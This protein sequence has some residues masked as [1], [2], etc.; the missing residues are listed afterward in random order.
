MRV[1]LA[2][3]TVPPNTEWIIDGGPPSVG[4]SV[5]VDVT[6]GQSRTI[7]ARTPDDNV[8]SLTAYFRYDT[9]PKNNPLSYS[10]VSGNIRDDQALIADENSNWRTTA[11]P[12]DTAYAEILTRINP[13]DVTI[14]GT[15]SYDGDDGKAQYNWLL[16]QR[17]AEGLRALLNDRYDPDFTGADEP[18][19]ASFSISWRDNVWRTQ[20]EPNRSR[21]WKA[22]ITGFLVNFP[23]EVITGMCGDRT[24]PIRHLP[25]KSLTHLPVNRQRRTGS[26]RPV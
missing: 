2:G 22:D 1:S 5:D 20:G 8:S 9:P 26:V 7:E 18:S 15:A 24:S 10:R 16:S 4:T 23:G 14:T 21:W 17:R 12:F 19:G 13:R 6:G 3:V 11:D 25:Q